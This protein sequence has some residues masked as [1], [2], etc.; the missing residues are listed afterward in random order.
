MGS[1]YINV[2]YIQLYVN[3]IFVKNQDLQITENEKSVKYN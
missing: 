3:Y 1:M 2:M